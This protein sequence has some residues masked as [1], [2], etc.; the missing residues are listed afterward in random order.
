MSAVHEIWNE[1]TKYYNPTIISLSKFIRCFARLG[2]LKLAC[3][4]LQQV[5]NLAFEGSSVVNKSSKG[6]FNKSKLDISIPSNKQ[7]M[8]DT[9]RCL[10][11]LL[12]ETEKGCRGSLCPADN[13]RN[14]SGFDCQETQSGGFKML[15]RDSRTIHLMT[16]HDG[17]VFHDTE[18]HSL[19]L[20]PFSHTYDGYARAVI[21][22][23]GVID[24]IKVVKAMIDMNLKPCSATM[25]ILSMRCSRILELDLAEDLLDH[26]VETLHLH[27]FNA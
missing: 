8:Y 24:G 12:V 9:S 21:Y 13:Q 18:M 1:F 7:F 14:D 3:E 10:G 17:F 23:K 27:P 11:G 5:V 2:D 15:K 22:D 16:A 20:E 26:I 4:A 6:Q 25:T 19:G